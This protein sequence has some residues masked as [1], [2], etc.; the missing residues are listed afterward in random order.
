M[1][2]AAIAESRAAETMREAAVAEARE[3]PCWKRARRWTPAG[4]HARRDRTVTVALALKRVQLET[5]EAE[6]LRAERPGCAL[7]RRSPARR[8]SPPACREAER[9]GQSRV[10]T[11]RRGARAH[12]SATGAEAFAAESPCARGSRKLAGDAARRRTHGIRADARRGSGRRTRAR[13]RR[14]QLKAELER[15]RFVATQPAG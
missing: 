12:R 4:A 14:S 10:G 6:R 1:R 3:P 15:L 11:R 5:E 9:F 2:E 13:R 7:P 8:G